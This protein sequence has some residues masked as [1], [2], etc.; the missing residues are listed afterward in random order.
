MKRILIIV[1]GTYSIA[2][3][4]SNSTTERVLIE[5]SRISV[6]VFSFNIVEIR[7]QQELTRPQSPFNLFCFTV[8]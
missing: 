5:D 2:F 1:K 4:N 3:C 7:R 6:C 8:P